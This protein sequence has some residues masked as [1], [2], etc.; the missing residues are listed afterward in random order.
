MTP[1][2]TTRHNIRG[3]TA[4]IHCSDEGTSRNL[5]DIIKIIHQSTLSNSIRDNVCAVFTRLAKAEAHVHGEHIEDVHFHEVGAMD[6]IIDISA[7]CIAIDM[8]KA[9]QIHFSE[10]CFGTG[11]INSRHGEIPVP[12]PAVVE[13]TKGFSC[14]HTRK[15]GELVTPTAAALLTTLGTQVGAASPAGTIIATGVGFG[16]RHYPFPSYTRAFFSETDDR[17][18]EQLVLLECNIDDMNPQVAPYLI[19]ILLGNGA[20][21]V[22]ATPAI[23]KKGR[24]GIVFSVLADDKNCTVLKEIIYRESTTL[25]IRI[26]RVEREKLHRRYHR[27]TVEGQKITIKTGILNGETVNIQPEYEDCR[28]AAEVTGKSLQNIMQEALK[29]YTD[30]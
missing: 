14:R 30:N 25:G 29:K 10:F 23:M 12:V 20:L 15:R 6:S 16:T 11:T 24:P 13:L 9:D 2:E 18:T 8:L 19:D 17:I 3:M 27:V 4:G 21:D 1:E 7:F 22:T 5:S 26:Q 28:K